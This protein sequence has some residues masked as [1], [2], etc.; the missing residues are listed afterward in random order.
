MVIGRA[1]NALLTDSPG[2]ANMATLASVSLC[3]Q[4]APVHTAAEIRNNHS[5]SL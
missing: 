3:G 4:F 5:R 2:L 1:P